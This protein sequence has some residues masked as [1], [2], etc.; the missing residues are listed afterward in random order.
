MQ[1]HTTSYSTKRPRRRARPQ[2]SPK[3]GYQLPRA[4]KQRRPGATYL[5]HSQ[6]FGRRRQGYRASG[7]NARRPYAF[8]AVGCALLFFIASVI[9]YM[10]RSVE[11]TFND[12]PASVRINATIQQFIDDNSLADTYEA[13]DLLAVDDS[14]LERGA[15]SRYTVTLDGKA[16]D[17]DDLGEIRLEG[18]EKLTIDDGVD[19]YEEHEVQATS[20]APKLTVEGTGA[21]GYVETWGIP[22]RSE[23]WTGA[24][25]GKTQD[26]GVVQQAQDCVVRQVSVLPADDEKLVALTFDEGPSAYTEQIVDILA[27]KGVDATFFL[28]GDAAEADPAAVRAIAEAG[29]ELGS[30]TYSDTDLSDLSSDEVRSQITKG[31]DA[32]EAACGTRPA[33]LRAPYASFTEENWSEAMDLVSAVVSWNV[34]S[35]DWLLPGADTVVSTVTGSVQPGNIVLLTDND[36]TGEQ[37]V[38]ALPTLIDQLQAAGYRIVSLS[39]LVASDE[40]LSG[41]IDLSRVTIP[42]GAVLPEVSDDAD[43]DA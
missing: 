18:G 33:L 6:G 27:E 37:L 9:W 3:G 26:R 31:F 30:N 12:E 7:G 25:S 23:V 41:A 15:G 14:V 16:V 42:E 29:F 35:G 13:G 36:S 4:Q 28:S 19:V 43:A 38:E 5:H 24:V 1:N 11:I 22:G 39:E 8:I 40:D 32:I 17:L 2:R 21:V 34:D 20:I 10:N